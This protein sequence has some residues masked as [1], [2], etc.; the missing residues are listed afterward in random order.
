MPCLTKSPRATGESSVIKKFVEKKTGVRFSPKSSGSKESKRC[1]R[2]DSARD[3]SLWTENVEPK[4]RASTGSLDP[5]ALL[6]ATPAPFNFHCNVFN[7]RPHWVRQS[8]YFR[9]AA[10]FIHCLNF[11]LESIVRSSPLSYATRSARRRRRQ[12]NGAMDR[13]R[14]VPSGRHA[15]FV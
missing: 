10:I 12:T 4:W 6:V 11:C 9:A 3:R 8:R 7:L 14:P 5:C 15:R 2:S 13:L 1:V